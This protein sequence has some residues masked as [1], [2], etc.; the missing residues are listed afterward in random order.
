MPLKTDYESL[1]IGGS[2]VKPQGSE[3]YTV[4]NPATEET[5]GEV[6]IG[7]AADA[8]A[9]IAAAREDTKIDKYTFNIEGVYKIKNDKMIITELPIGEWT[10]NYKEYL[11]KLLD[12]ESSKKTRTFLGYKDKNTDE[13]VHFE[14][15]FTKGY[16]DSAK[17][18]NKLFHLQKSI[19][20]TN[21]HL[22]CVDGSIKKYNT[23]KEIIQEFYIERLNIYD[24]RR[25]YILNQLKYQLDILSYKVKFI[26]MVVKKELKINNRKK[27][28]IEHDLNEK[29]F[30]KYGKNIDDENKTY[31]YLLGMS[32]YS[33]TYEKIEELKIQMENKET[34]YN[35]LFNKTSKD[36]WKDELNDLLNKL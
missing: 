10:T 2:W 7:T 16:L 20:L 29:K 5:I 21:M 34:A 1:Y 6:P 15:S 26:L 30:P 13:K 28:I 24:K 27:D 14:L 19:K 18:L 22:Y 35:E 8:D 23:V 11:E 25:E 17:D 12:N 31:N 32:I 3:T 33:L 9:A 4:I 36:L